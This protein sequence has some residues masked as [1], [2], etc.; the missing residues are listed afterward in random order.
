[1]NRILPPGD[2]SGSVRAP[3]SKSQAH[4]ALILAAIGQEE[5]AVVCHGFSGDIA[6]TVRCLAALGAGIRR[7]GD[8]LLVT[9]LSAPPEGVRH[10]AC[11][12]S[13][14]TLR[15]LLPLAGVL[16]AQA[17]FHMD[18]RLPQ[19]PVEPLLRALVRQGMSIR[20]GENSL[21]V[22]GRLRPGDF[23]LP[24]NVSSQYLSGVMMA[25]PLLPG[26]SRLTVEGTLA[27]GGYVALTEQMLRQGGIRFARRGDRWDIPGQQRC[28]LP[29][30][31]RIQGDWSAA[32]VFLC[33]GALQR[34]GVTVRGLELSSCQGDRQVL[35][36]LE[37]MGAQVSCTQKGVTVCRGRELR[38]VEIDAG[39]IPDLVP[40][41]SVLAAAAG[42]DSRI[43]NAGRL[44]TKESDRLSSS[45]ALIADLGGQVQEQAEGLL[46]RGGGLLGG[47]GDSRGDH[48]IAMSAAVAACACRRAVTVTRS[49]C[50][51]KSYPAFWRDFASLKGGGA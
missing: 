33:I 5:T 26:P 6:A 27:S 25:L 4:R 32:A 48:R 23:S 50:V 18:G 13:G 43:V 7:R 31:V 36:I 15:F 29:R 46:I 41:L 40:A 22:S 19:R 9:P 44:R 2:R 42:G 11:G 35:E 28:A 20:R 45:A 21:Y 38:G 16:G 30:E 14:S 47:R 12:E 51:D 8:T 34:S 10:L 1:M 3:G 39:P 24:G 37:Q 49:Q 17:V